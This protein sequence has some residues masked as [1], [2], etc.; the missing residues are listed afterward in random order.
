MKKI[1]DLVKKKKNGKL[2]LLNTDNFH[3][4][5][6]SEKKF[7]EETST[8]YKK[9]KF[10]S[11]LNNR[12]GLLG[13]TSEDENIEKRSIYFAVTG[14]CN[15]NCSFCTMN[16][17]PYVSTEKDLTIGEISN[18]LIPQLK[19]VGIRKIVITGGEPLVRGDIEEIIGLFSEAFGKEQIVLQTNGLLLTP[20]FLLRM[21]NNIG[22]LEVSIENI[23]EDN[24]LLSKMKNMFACANDAGIMLSLSFV[25]NDNTLK[26]LHEGIDLC[27]QYKA[28]LTT[29]IVSLVGRA[30]ENEEIKAFSMNTYT[31]LKIQY[32]IIQYFLDKKYFNEVLTKGIIGELHPAR[33]CGAYG[34]IL[35]IH[36]DGTVYMCGNFKNERYS[37]GNIRCQTIEEICRNLVDRKKSEEYRNLFW[38]DR[39]IACKNCEYIYF[40]SGPCIAEMAESEDILKD[41]D[42]CIYN[43]IMLN[44]I[45]YY[46]RQNSIEDSLRHTAAYIAECI[47]NYESD[48]S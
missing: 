35:A 7:I 41:G 6:M 12:F 8:E 31:R 23:F 22:V 20:D 25:V 40:C 28:A 37:L 3:W 4:A 5:K 48:S 21:A 45:L 18:L 38:V 46:D 9:E 17:G 26:Y 19:N 10:S 11:Y 29:R 16:S 14:K 43:K 2:I 33:S 34:K 24:N 15:L 42:K 47:K 44:Y 27:H 13:E 30:A 36:P 1:E 39:H 32:D